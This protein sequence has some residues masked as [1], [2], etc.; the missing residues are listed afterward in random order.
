MADES[1]A[2]AA[3]SAAGDD[4]H[5]LWALRKIMRLLD[6]KAR[7]VSVTVEGVPP[8]KHHAALGPNA[9]AVDVTEHF[10]D[11]SG[12][13]AFAYEQLKY[14][15]AH[16]EKAWTWARLTAEVGPKRKGTSILGKLSQTHHSLGG[17]GIVRIVSNQPVAKDL[18][19]DVTRLAKL[20][21]AN[22]DA[23]EDL[24]TLTRLRSATGLDDA[25]LA[26]FLE[27]WDLSTFDSAGRLGLQGDVLRR[28]SDLTD[29]DARSDL[30]LLQQQVA[31]LILPSGRKH[32][33]VTREM[34]L[35]WLGA[36][37]SN[38]LF[39][40]P[41]Q[42]T[43]PTFVLERADASDM[44]K[45]IVASPSPFVRLH[46]PGG[47]GKTT[48]VAGLAPHLPT[49]SVTVLYDCYGGGLFMS[50]DQRRHAPQQAFVQ[51]ANE[52]A[53]SLG[54]PFVLSRPSGTDLT[55][56]FARR[57]RAASALAAN[58]SPE[59]LVVLVFDAADNARMAAKKWNEPCFLDELFSLSNLPA[60]VR[61][62]LTCRT[63]RRDWINPPSFTDIVL[64]PFSAEETRDYLQVMR[65]NWSQSAIDALQDLSGG[66]PR[67]LAYALDKAV[68][69]NAAIERLMP[70]AA[71][72]DPLFEHLVVEAG[73]R[74]GDEG[75]VWRVLCALANIPRPSPAWAL[76]QIAGLVESDIADIAADVGGIV[77]HREGWSFQD[78][79]FEG[80]VDER[81]REQADDL[82]QWA[83]EVIAPLTETHPYAAR[84]LAELL[85]RAGDFEA[86]Y[87]LVL[88]NAPY[89]CISDEIERRALQARRMAIALNCCRQADDPLTAVNLLLA[90]TKGMKADEAIR[91]IIA[92]NLDVS[93]VLVPEAAFRLLTTHRR[94][95]NRRGRLRVHL[96]AQ[97]GACPVE[98]AN[99]L[100]WW[101]AW[102]LDRSRQKTK[103]SIETCDVVA[104]V[105]AAYND[106][107]FEGAVKR[108]R[109][110]TPAAA[111][112]PV[113][114]EL[115]KQAARTAPDLLWAGLEARPKRPTIILTLLAQLI[116][117]RQT[118]SD[119]RFAQALI[120]VSASTSWLRR[121]YLD[122]AE[123]SV[124]LEDLL[125]V[126][127]AAVDQPPLQQAVSNLL[128]VALPPHD[129]TVSS[130]V[131]RFIGSG[132]RARA[133]ALTEVIQGVPVSLEAVL[134]KKAPPPFPVEYQRGR[135]IELPKDQE[136][137]NTA[138]ESLNSAINEAL[139]TLGPL[140]DIARARI[141]VQKDGDWDDVIAACYEAARL[142][143]RRQSSAYR[144]QKGLS[145]Q[146]A[147][148]LEQLSVAGQLTSARLAELTK[149]LVSTPSYGAGSGPLQA[150]S[151]LS[152]IPSADDMV[153]QAASL[154]TAAVE[155]QQRPASERANELVGLARIVLDLDPALARDAFE[156]AVRV[157][158]H[159]D[160]QTASQLRLV[161]SLGH[162]NLYADR[163][164]ARALAEQFA[165]VASA[166]DRL[167][168]RSDSFPWMAVIEGLARIDLP[169]AYAA[170]SRWSDMGTV[171]LNVGVTGLLESEVGLDL[172]PAVQLALATLS[173][174]E[175]LQVVQTFSSHDQAAAW[176]DFQSRDAMAAADEDRVL[177]IMD[178]AQAENL[179]ISAQLALAARA[180]EAWDS[181]G[182]RNDIAEDDEDRFEVGG[183]APLATESGVRAAV[184]AISTDDY[185][186]VSQV[187][188]LARRLKRPPLRA[189][190]LGMLLERFP[191]NRALAEVIQYKYAD[192][193]TY[194][195]VANWA[196]DH[197][198]DYLVGAL[199][200][201]FH[202]DYHDTSMVEAVLDAS[203]RDA[204]D[205][206][207]L[208]F[209]AISQQAQVINGDLM[210]GLLCVIARRLPAGD[211]APLIGSILGDIEQY[212]DQQPP[213]VVRGANA[214][215][216]PGQALA[217]FLF[218]VMGDVDR[219]RRWHASHA[220]RR[221]V[222][223]GED[224]ILEALAPMLLI[225]APVPFAAQEARFYTFSARQQLA[226]VFY[227]IAIENPSAVRPH[228]PSLV[229]CAL[230]TEPHVIVTSFAKAAAMA[231]E[232]AFPNSLSSAEKDGL[233][234]LNTSPY[235]ATRG[236]KRDNERPHRG[237]A[238][239]SKRQFDFDDT[240]TI[241]Y[242]F[243]PAARA[244]D[245]DF[246]TFLDRIEHWVVERW[247]FGEQDTYWSREPRASR[248]AD[249]DTSHRHGS[250][251]T[252]ERQSRYADWHGLMC[253]MGQTLALDPAVF[254][255]GE[256][257]WESWFGARL[258]TQPDVW[259]ADLRDPP[260]L[261]KRFWR[262]ENEQDL[263]IITTGR[264]SQ[265]RFNA[266]LGL[267]DSQD[268]LFVSGR[269][270]RRT[271]GWS[272]TVSISSALVSSPTAMALG[273]A[274]QTARDR[275]DYILP[276]ADDHRGITH[277][278]FVLSGWLHEGRDS[279]AFDEHDPRRGA[280]NGLPVTP[281][282]KVVRHLGL[283][284]DLAARQWHDPQQTSRYL[285]FSMWGHA[286]DEGF[287]EGWR[288]G[289]SKSFLDALIQNSDRSLLIEVNISGTL[290]RSYE[291][292]RAARRLY[293]VR[294]GG[295]IEPVAITRRSWACKMVRALGLGRSVD[296]LG[297]WMLHEIEAQAMIVAAGGAQAAAAEKN[298]QALVARF[299]VRPHRL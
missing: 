252:L 39:P 272:E 59:A 235:A 291:D 173:G 245:V 24:L 38:I 70:K 30:T 274:F 286:G 44:I 47:C 203:Q 290:G 19:D 267:G 171:E 123:A 42:I 77:E 81:T 202:Y 99:H 109:C 268:R 180:I 163:A 242:W 33:Q 46:A 35:T 128:T 136:S 200:D 179:P 48:F 51:I 262:P 54:S 196:R 37:A 249:G 270:A 265:E 21:R 2:G 244:F 5:E 177:G 17:K 234:Q 62:V 74:I 95:T 182:D 151:V 78:E 209:K 15:A 256:N 162:P 88:A 251:P 258:L 257:E 184:A 167:L 98:A 79:D 220:V 191:N 116:R 134:P 124:L 115:A 122:N 217:G 75:A 211:R 201:L 157:V 40:A 73:Q 176:V 238:K 273:R 63:A 280:V 7:L 285:D 178:G 247:G 3:A 172:S 127:E 266:E 132:S 102:M 72:M 100:R 41:H 125:L 1:I 219:R 86:L 165:D 85:M 193:S 108:L 111:M 22:I 215:D 195:P 263:K 213:V 140:L 53:G 294:Y 80:F 149:L 243:V 150:L 83:V 36:G 275:M 117:A 295:A 97:T 107:G 194:P 152:W 110:W 138:Q 254:E 71:G 55:A 230:R 210:Y 6:H 119:P 250:M 226:A 277:A 289:A 103:W 45:A 225:E 283:E 287:A 264:W 239:A 10:L 60:N 299:R 16:P 233:A 144:L 237:Q 31:E 212:L 84:S 255:Y 296:T 76:A 28:I 197:L 25:A 188:D 8:D 153:L 148:L 135:K 229:A 56:S 158:E 104:E 96:A 175:D 67:R 292:R 4:F 113:V 231:V 130:G 189:P 253:A 52:L 174:K 190:F 101:R 156:R 170:I 82:L 297:R 155:A 93:A 65:P 90:S 282:A 298:L 261:E 269:H 23:D 187:R 192:W 218:A 118:A 142:G 168:D 49:G 131:Y 227:R 279:S 87:A 224:A 232:G 92:D 206:C 160:I 12:A 164:K 216:D 236:E 183:Q 61:I 276:P 145:R 64:G 147:A 221:L 222:A 223:L 205:Q 114:R 159:I 32:A 207:A 58:N 26:T 129:L 288:A 57:V 181:N 139:G 69:P 281:S 50:S 68:D 278:G 166:T 199:P 66:T 133:L 186:A 105:R 9:Q 141:A 112:A 43:S 214:P 120:R 146:I 121:Q 208:L 94:Y 204:R 106:A 29:A 14:S 241:P 161:A 143:D 91:N 185:A 126:C 34:L 137:A 246:P 293:V 240:D 20:L 18:P 89:P 169:S 228:L 154:L 198:P 27:A 260:P 284:L 11:D 248:F 259:L 271:E 13:P